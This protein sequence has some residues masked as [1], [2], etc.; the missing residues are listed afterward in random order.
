MKEIVNKMDATILSVLALFGI[1]M[2]IVVFIMVGYLIPE[3]V[4][5]L[6]RRRQIR[7]IQKHRFDGPPTAKCYCVDCKCWNK[8]KQACR[9][10]SGW[11]TAP[12]WFCCDAEPR[13]NFGDYKEEWE[14][15]GKR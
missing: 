4:S 13:T 15:G 8:A 6:I 7:Y 5:E 11:Y 10:H 3:I 1:V 2:I 12:D 14:G 9:A